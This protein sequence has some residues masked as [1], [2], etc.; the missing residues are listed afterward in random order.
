MA[1]SGVAVGGTIVAVAVAVRAAV[2][3]VGTVVAVAVA[4]VVGVA[5]AVDG[6]IVAVDVRAGAI[7]GETGVAVALGSGVGVAVAMT[8][9]LVGMSVSDGITEDVASGEAGLPGP[10]CCSTGMKTWC[11]GSVGNPI[12]KRPLARG[13]LDAF[14]GVESLRRGSPT[15]LAGAQPNQ[16]RH[17]WAD[18]DN[19]PN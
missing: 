19:R 5:V 9:V 11:A 12:M 17:D 4:A 18:E 1:R 13:Y 14:R 3:V 16:A 7:V 2:A 6:T 15:R 10:L 8:G